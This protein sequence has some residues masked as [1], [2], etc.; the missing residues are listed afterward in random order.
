MCH[1]LSWFY[2][3]FIIK[4]KNKTGSC[5]AWWHKP[6]VPALGRQRQEGLCEFK[7]SQGYSEK[8][9]LKTKQNKTKQNKTKQNKT[10]QNPNKRRPCVAQMGFRLDTQPRKTLNF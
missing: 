1:S 2:Y 4:N 10:K 9:C 8:P 7:A 3:V 5:W 6:L